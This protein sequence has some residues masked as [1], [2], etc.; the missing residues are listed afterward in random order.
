MSTSPSASELHRCVADFL[1]A[2]AREDASPHTRRAYAGDLRQ[3]VT[4]AAAKTARGQPLRWDALLVREWL[5]ELYRRKLR[6]V[7]LRRKLAALRSFFQFLVQQGTLEVNPARLTATPKAPKTLPRVL[8]AEQINR[9]LDALASQPEQ[10]RLVR[11]TAILELLY[12]C[13]L[14]VSELV[15]LDEADLDAAEGW[16]RVRGKGRKERQVPIPGRAAETLRRYLAV[17]RPAPGER[18]LFLNP[19]G[20]RLTDRSVR[21]IVK[22]YARGLAGDPSLHPHSFRHAYA[23]HLL[24][25]GADLRA[26]Q[27]LLGHARLSTTQ[28]YTQLSLQ[29][30]IAIYDRTHP[31]A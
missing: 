2:L 4:F 14:R 28:K 18:A 24:A 17:R 29:D 10:P 9:F 13:G 25:E 23:T 27:E 6:P 1:T 26:I 12:G 30:L 20:H 8:T 22:R 11:D 19:R 16:L 21:N 7:T 31:R 5:A 15:G 3:F